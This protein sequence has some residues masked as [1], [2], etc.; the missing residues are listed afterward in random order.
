[1]QRIIDAI[2]SAMQAAGFSAV[3]RG[4]SA[5]MGKLT[6]A[7]TAVSLASAVCTE[8]IAYRYLGTREQPSGIVLPLY[9][10]KTALEAVLEVFAP[11][12]LGAAACSAEA[13]KLMQFLL[14]GIDGVRVQKLEVGPCTFEP[15]ADVFCV[16]ITLTAEGFLYALANEDDTEFTDFILKGEIR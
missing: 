5:K 2:F 16:K 1:M 6:A 7:K 4:G 11:R 15:E 13:E 8:P 3:R 10:C 9:G 14:G 12:T